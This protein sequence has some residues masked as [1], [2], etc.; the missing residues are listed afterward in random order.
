MSSIP[1]PKTFEIFLL[2]QQNNMNFTPHGYSSSNATLGTGF[3]LTEKEA[4]HQRTLEILKN[5][6]SKYYIFPLTIDN[7]AYKEKYEI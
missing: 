1:V 2:L 3:F 5:P 4:E 7:P 6:G